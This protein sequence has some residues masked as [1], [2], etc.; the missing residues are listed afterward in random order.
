MSETADPLL[1]LEAALPD[2]QGAVKQQHLGTAL[3]AA[4]VACEVMPLRLQRLT[5]LIEVFAQLPDYLGPLTARIDDEA[6]DI[7]E[8]GERMAGASDIAD[9]EAI[10]RE[11]RTLEHTLNRLHAIAI[12][13]AAAYA[14][15]YIVPL[16]ALEKLLPRLGRADLASA[17]GRLR[18]IESG[19]KSAGNALPERL[20]SLQ[21][22]RHALAQDLNRLAS[23]P[24]VDGFLTG[25]ATNGS[26]TLALVTKRVLD[27]LSD[28]SALDQFTVQPG[29]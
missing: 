2:L 6:A 5:A 18:M 3:G 28:Q 15:E 12:E 7:L 10:A 13:L 25:F 19:L 20:K 14:R 11:V 26:V 23:D 1:R 21:D 29:D 16:S 22:A 4:I 9:L 24:E 8:L 27:W 17:I